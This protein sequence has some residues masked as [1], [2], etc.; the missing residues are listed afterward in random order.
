MSKHFL[1]RGVKA[2]IPAQKALWGSVFGD[3]CAEID[4][5]F[6]AFGDVLTS[7][8]AE[9]D[10]RLAAMGFLLPVGVFR[11]SGKTDIPCAMIYAVATDPSMRRLG[12][13]GEIT[14]ALLESSETLGY[15]ETVLHPATPELFEFY[16]KNSGM[17]AAYFC[18]ETLCSAGQLRRNSYG[19][20]KLRRA[21]A[22]EYLEVREEILEKTPHITFDERSFAYQQSVCG[23]GGLMICEDGDSKHACAIV[24][25]VDGAVR[26][27]ELLGRGEPLL[28]GL[29][30]DL[31]A[32]EYFVRQA[33]K[34]V[35]FGMSSRK[36]SPKNAWFGPAF[37]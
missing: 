18:S 6:D 23:S 16:S 28:S 11:E 7:V 9:I 15:G 31:P 27:I 33:G 19:G 1:R 13:G 5:F 30:N 25:A 32:D 10:E 20:D 12:L 4:A 22:R 36:I 37:E 3:S 34:S 29:T 17:T 26:V 2:D 24:E 14:R 8:V 35:A 21:D